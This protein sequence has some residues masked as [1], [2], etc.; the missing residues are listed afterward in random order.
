MAGAVRITAPKL[1]Q[2]DLS[3]KW[4]GSDAYFSGGG[5]FAAA[6][7]VIFGKPMSRRRL[8]FADSGRPGGPKTSGGDLESGGAKTAPNLRQESADFAIFAFFAT[9]RIS[10]L[11]GINGH[12]WFDSRRLHHT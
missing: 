2:R 8:F 7:T 10:N 12:F 5:G 1:R 9:F 3:G 4:A 6:S 11:R